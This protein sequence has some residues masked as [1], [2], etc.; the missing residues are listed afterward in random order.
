MGRSR[1]YANGAE[2]QRAYRQRLASQQPGQPPSPSSS[3]ERKPSRPAR[4][5]NLKA[6]AEQLLAEYEEWLASVPEPLQDS[7]QAHLLAATIEQLEAV[8]EALSE[9]QPPRGFGRD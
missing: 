5:A 2:R 8:V 4:L 7:Q 6:G 3:R 9:I 1:Q